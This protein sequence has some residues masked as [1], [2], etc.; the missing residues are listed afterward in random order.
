MS[1]NKAILIG[2]VGKDPDVRHLDNDVTVARFTLATSES[3]KKSN[4]EVVK[5]TE[6]HNI[7]LW[8][9][10]AQVAEKYVKKG[11]QIYIEG[12]IRTRS[13][14]DKDGNKK[15][16]TEIQGDNLTLLGKKESSDSTQVAPTNEVGTNNQIDINQGTPTDDLPF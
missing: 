3:Y 2:N 4:G 5:T 9:G 11:S 7:V 6:W 13:Y 16:F 1:V 14:D 8:R 15:Y 12:K 10:L